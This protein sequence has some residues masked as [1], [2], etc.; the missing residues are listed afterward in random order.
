MSYETGAALLE[1]GK[2]AEAVPHLAKVRTPEAQAALGRAYLALDQPAKAVPALRAGLAAD[3]DGSVHFQLA[4]A[5]QRTGAAAQAQEMDRI[6]QQLRRAQAEQQ[7]AVNA[8]QI[9][10]P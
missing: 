10:P 7:D 8:V 5:L 6:S 9:T 2:A 3:R 4:R 1:T